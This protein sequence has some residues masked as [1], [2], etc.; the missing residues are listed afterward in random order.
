MECNILNLAHVLPAGWRTKR[1]I[2][3]INEAYMMQA[4]MVG[5]NSPGTEKNG[6]GETS[7]MHTNVYM[8]HMSYM[9]V[10]VRMYCCMCVCCAYTRVSKHVCIHARVRACMYVCVCLLAFCTS[11]PI[12]RVPSFLG[13]IGVRRNKQ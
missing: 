5:G 11:L 2:A 4:C 7:H 3:K 6:I 13:M 9:H 8:S 10:C 12:R 1:R